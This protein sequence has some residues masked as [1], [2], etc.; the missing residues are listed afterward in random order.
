MSTATIYPAHPQLTGVPET[1][2]E[3]RIR[4]WVRVADFC[5]VLTL[6]GMEMFGLYLS[7]R[8]NNAMA[9]ALWLQRLCK[10][11]VR[12]IDLRAAYRGEPAKE[13]LFVFNH[14]SY[15]DIITLSARHPVVFVAKKEVRSWPVIGWLAASAGTI[16]IDRTKRSDVARITAEMSELLAQGVRV[17]IF[18]EGTSSN[19]SRVLPFRTSLLEPAIANEQTVTA[20]WIGYT[21]DDGDPATEVCY[22]GDLTFGPHLLNLFSKRCVY[23]TVAYAPAGKGTGCRKE[24]GQ[25]LHSLVCDLAK[26]RV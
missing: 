22:W 10:R 17:C 20:G 21:L 25:R 2:L 26:Q 23:A 13:G 16:F 4:Q 3:A 8:A 15:I 24:F 18:P 7:G 14:V 12:T 19:G 5:R 11:L 1:P 6:A 9:R